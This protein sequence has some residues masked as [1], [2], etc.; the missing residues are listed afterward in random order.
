MQ[1]MPAA[2]VEV[3]LKKIPGARVVTP[4]AV[5]RHFQRS[6]HHLAL[7]QPSAET[8]AEVIFRCYELLADPLVSIYWA[9]E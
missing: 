6:I 4:A 3:C 7:T 9:V 5:C 1:D 8:N 2:L